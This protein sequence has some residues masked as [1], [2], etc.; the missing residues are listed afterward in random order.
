[1]GSVC[2]VWL[3]VGFRVPEDSF[4]D[5]FTEWHDEIFKFVRQWDSD[6]GKELPKKRVVVKPRRRS[7]YRIIP[8]DEEFDALEEFVEA[9]GAKAE[10]SF[11]IVYEEFVF[12]SPNLEIEEDDGQHYTT[13]GGGVADFETVAALG[14]ELARIKEFFKV[15]GLD[16]GRSIVAI[17]TSVN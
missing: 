10:C 1:M 2:R 4:D 14:P 11:N 13:V 16:V 6:T 12:I 9:L 15:L 17:G 7:G 5:A 8:G 3:H